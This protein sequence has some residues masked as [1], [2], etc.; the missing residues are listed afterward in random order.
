MRDRGVEV[1]DAE[2]LLTDVLDLPEAREWVLDRVLDERHVGLYLA[3]SRHEWGHGASSSELADRLI[4]GITKRD[5]PDG[6]GLT[7][8]SSELN[9]TLLPPLP[10][11]IFQR[12]P[13]CWIYDGVT[14]NA[15]AKPARRR[16]DHLHGGDLSLAP[17]VRP[18]RRRQGLAWR[19]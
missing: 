9:D 13:S 11:F 8:D 7:Y 16:G 2:D 4:G 12:D 19:R 17:D 3:R 14:L 18:G 1:L 15:M 10:N 5:L 6:E